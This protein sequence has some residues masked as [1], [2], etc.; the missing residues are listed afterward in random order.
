MPSASY[1]DI[2]SMITK[3]KCKFTSSAP[4]LLIQRCWDSFHS[5]AFTHGLG[6]KREGE[7]P[8]CRHTIYHWPMRARMVY[9][10]VERSPRLGWLRETPGLR[11]LDSK[12]VYLAML[13]Y[14][15]KC[16]IIVVVIV[17]VT[18]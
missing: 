7:E 13:I 5:A 16:I 2:L 6:F 18:F 14:F 10:A 4:E 12:P 3:N 1:L 17:T 9:K 15:L 8:S 11:L